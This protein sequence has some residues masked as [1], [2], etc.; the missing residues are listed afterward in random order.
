[1]RTPADDGWSEALRATHLALSEADLKFREH[2]RRDPQLL[3]RATFSA[4][5][6]D[7]RLRYRQ[8]SW[9]TFVGRAKLEQLERVTL[10]LAALVRSVPRRIFRGDAARICEF[11][12]LPSREAAEIIL[13]E[14]SGIE[15]GLARADLIDSADGFKCLEV[16]FSADLGGWETSL[17]AEL[18]GRVPET[19]GFLAREGI[20]VSYAPTL[21]VLFKEVISRA[22]QQRVCERGELNLA[23]VFDAARLAEP[24]TPA[25][26]ALCQRELDLGC[27]DSGSGLHGK[28]VACR[29]DQLL[30]VQGNL[31]CQK[32]RVHA[33][34]ELCPGHVAAAVYRL[35]KTGKVLLFNGPI[36]DVLSE[37]RN[38]AL[39]SENEGA[40]AFSAAERETIR[41]HIPWTR[42]VHP[43]QVSFAGGEADLP[44][45]LAAARERLVLKEGKNFGGKGVFLGHA[46]SAA[47]W[48]E[49]A[50]TA[51]AAGGWVVQEHVQ[52]LPY[53]YQCGDAGCAPHDVIWGPFVFGRTYGGVIL[54]M[55]PQ[56][57]GG[58]VN[59]SL[60]ATE[61]IV[62][63]V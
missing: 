15:D 5:E 23:C 9:P 55:Q 16:N 2:A 13:S 46:T 61:G 43:G 29:P 3:R 19:T 7:V 37:K 60:T 44:E 18:H 26:I 32:L 35:F 36:D 52:S 17:L 10:A 59:A 54:R 56:A 51:L 25:Q 57:A 42:R 14:P 63:E 28:V 1:M 49:L 12:G 48:E 30:A 62:Y 6:G 38:I 20:Q 21:Q 34:F 24:G 41:N 4:L 47:R 11:Y 31:F 27:R 58:S 39:L 40:G 8:Q 53:L 33:V 22:V 45:L 50:R